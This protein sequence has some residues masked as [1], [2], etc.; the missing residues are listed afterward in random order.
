MAKTNEALDNGA[1]SFSKDSVIV[2]DDAVYN[3]ELLGELSD[4][5]KFNEETAYIDNNVFYVFKGVPKSSEFDKLKPGIYQNKEGSPK[6]FIV[7]PVTEEELAEYS[8]TDHVASL[9]PTSIIDT[10]NTKED[11]LI[12]IP[13][14]T[15]VFQPVLLDTDD[16]LKRVLKTVLL[17]KNVD[18]DRYKDRFRNKNEL[19]NLKQVIRGKNKVSILIFDRGCEALN[20]KYTITVEE[21]SDDDIVGT[22][23]PEPIVVSSEDTYQL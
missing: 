15:K 10:A 6:Y 1:L 18:L 3:I 8:V 21:K 20:V 9:I 4:D 7:E 16:I 22:K 14:S 23:L 17:Q 5:M 12:A 13:E 2:T 11:L 19:F